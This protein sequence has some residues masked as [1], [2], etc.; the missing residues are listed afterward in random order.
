M[1][2]TSFSKAVQR[3]LAQNSSRASPISL[4]LNVKQ[5]FTPGMDAPFAS[6]GNPQRNMSPTKHPWTHTRISILPSSKCVSVPSCKPAIP[7]HPYPPK[8]RALSQKVHLV[9][10]F[11]D[12]K[13][14]ENRPRVR[15]SQT[16]LY[17]RG[18]AGHLCLLMWTLLKADGRA[19]VRSR[20]VLLIRRY[21]RRHL[22]ICLDRLRLLRPRRFHPVL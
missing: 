1:A 8:R 12:R 19:P 17:A 14:L 22:R 21:R 20:R 16:M 5:L 9:C 7:Q 4:V 3:Y 15:C 13:T 11:L 6:L 2:N 18:S 10:S